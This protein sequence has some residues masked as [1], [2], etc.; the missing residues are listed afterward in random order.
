M[1]TKNITIVKHPLI[2]HSL[3]ILRD[4]KTKTEEFRRHAN[5]VSKILLVEAAK[6]LPL[7]N[8]KIETPLASM[9]G[10]ILTDEIVV[11]PVLRAGLAM[12]FSLQDFLPSVSVGFIGLERDEK[13]AVAREYYQKLP[14]IFA[15]HH[16]FV[17]DPMLATGGSF[18]DTITALRAKGGKRISI[19][20]IV[21]APAGIERI[22]KNH[23]DVE[24]FTAAVDT[25]LNSKKYIVPGLGDFG[26]RY[27]G[28]Q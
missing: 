14:D 27:F 9:T 10:R 17:L 11:V 15:T 2:D 1:Y 8:K 21:S 19:V 24:I 26:D 20:C 18:D 6:H 16:V 3:T 28:T 7:K 4:K 12:L 23:P 25:S 5:I 13:T 22:Q